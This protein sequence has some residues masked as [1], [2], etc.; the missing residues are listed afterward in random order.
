[1]L[2]LMKIPER[3]SIKLFSAFI[4]LTVLILAMTLL[5]AHWSFRWGFI[6]F[7]HAQEQQRLAPTISTL[8]QEYAKSG[9]WDFVAQQDLNEVSRQQRRLQSPRSQSTNIASQR[10]RQLWTTSKNSWI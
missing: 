9:N 5:L 8:Q 10:L 3:L 4:G 7:I 6:N 2:A 1:M